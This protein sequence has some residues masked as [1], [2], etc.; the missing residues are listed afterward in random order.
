MSEHFALFTGKGRVSFKAR[1]QNEK[2]RSRISFG[3][4][5]KGKYG[6]VE[7]YN[8]YAYGDLAEK[9]GAQFE[10][11]NDV[12]VSGRLDAQRDFGPRGDIQHFNVVI[13]NIIEQVKNAEN[14]DDKNRQEVTFNKQKNNV[15]E[16]GYRA[17]ASRD[18]KHEESV[19]FSK[20]ENSTVIDKI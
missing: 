9:V 19:T 13:V 12:I 15:E 3:L 8:C 6:V 14:L 16:P 4:Q 7:T 18:N 5:I 17:D 20:E 1:V 2:G 11:G 10:E